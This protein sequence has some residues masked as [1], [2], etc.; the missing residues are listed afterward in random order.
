MAISVCIAQCKVSRYSC[1]TIQDILI[2]VID[3]SLYFD[4]YKKL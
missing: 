4:I 3:E 1:E 2:N